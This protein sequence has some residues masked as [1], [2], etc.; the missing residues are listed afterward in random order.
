[1]SAYLPRCC[2][3]WWE[4]GEHV[5]GHNELAAVCRHTPSGGTAGEPDGVT[6]CNRIIGRGQTRRAAM[7]DAREYLAP[8]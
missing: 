3:C 2:R 7:A 4:G 5:V 8:D 1:M 6:P